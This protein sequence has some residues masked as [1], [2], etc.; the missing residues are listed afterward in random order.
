MANIIIIEDD[1][2]L[3]KMLRQMLEREGYE[4]LEASDGTEGIKIY[5]EKPTDIVITDMI[6]DGKEGVET[7]IEL[8]REFPDVKIIAISGGGRL[9][10]EVYLDMAHKL[11]VLQTLTKPFDRKELLETVRKIL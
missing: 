11:G 2:Q 5:R 1:V 7:I 10:P 8:K 4:I 3:R 9:N 6:M